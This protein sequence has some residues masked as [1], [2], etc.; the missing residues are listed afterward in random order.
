[1]EEGKRYSILPNWVTAKDE[2]RKKLEGEISLLNPN[3]LSLFNGIMD[4]VE[5]YHTAY[6]PI[7]GLTK[8]IIEY[9]MKIDNPALKNQN[10]M[11]EILKP[12]YSLLYKEKYC[13]PEMSDKKIVA[14]IL[15]DPKAPSMDEIKSIIKLLKDE[16]EKCRNDQKKPFFSMNNFRGFHFY[17]DTVYVIS[18]KEYVEK[19]TVNINITHPLCKILLPENYDIFFPSELFSDIYKISLVKIQL[20]L[21]FSENARLIFNKLKERFSSFKVLKEIKEAFP[22]EKQSSDVLSTIATEILG[23]IQSIEKD[24]ALWEACQIIQALA[25]KQGADSQKRLL[26]KE[27]FSI[28][29]KIVEKIPS[30]FNRSTLLKLRDNY[31]TFK[32]FEMGDYT[33]IVDEFLISYSSKDASMPLIYTDFHNEKIYI[34]RDNF[35]KNLMA[36][37]DRNFLEIHKKF[38]TE[39]THRAKAFLKESFMK[40]ENSFEEH[41][42]NIL[43]SENSFIVPFLKDPKCLLNI[44]VYSEKNIPEAKDCV[45]KFF[46]KKSDGVIVL[47]PFSVI[48]DLNYKKILKEA[49][50]YLPF[51]DQFNIFE[52]I[53]SFFKNFG[54]NFAKALDSQIKKKKEM[55][56]LDEIIKPLTVKFNRTK[57]ETTVKINKIAENKPSTTK[58]SLEEMK[59]EMLGNSDLE[60]MLTFYE[61]RWNHIL[62]KET[63]NENLKYVKDRIASRVKFI[64]KPTPES[65]IKEVDDLIATDKNLQG[66]SDQDA[67]RKYLTLVIIECFLKK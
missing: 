30:F 53:I 35:Y 8:H 15:K 20:Y 58:L 59:R 17:P 62:N 37:L 65:I 38:S 43:F 1:M 10:S 4:Y 51:F 36:F 34:S 16:Y 33:K 39:Y 12:L 25:Y 21:T 27:A 14:F 40:D 56:K 32:I 11:M 55:P 13:A 29:L 26:T 57:K 67:L 45:K 64:K 52:F 6:L 28:M 23:Y 31:T 18:L 5:K 50:L 54:K 63:R 46:Y 49:K 9:G 22:L 24:L 61:N 47:R 19:V 7:E 42:K 60:E 66:I 48:L 3:A 41:L 2:E 44:L